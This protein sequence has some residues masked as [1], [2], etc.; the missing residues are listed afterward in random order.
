MKFKNK[1]I[2]QV[3]QIYQLNDTYYEI[4]SVEPGGLRV[5]VYEK[6]Y[7]QPREVKFGSTLEERWIQTNIKLK[8]VKARLL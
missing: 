7:S 8:N 5:I 4:K 2:Y 6:N 1:Y 3:G